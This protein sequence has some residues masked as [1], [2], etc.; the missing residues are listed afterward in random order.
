LGSLSND[1][2][3][4]DKK[5]AK[6]VRRVRKSIIPKG[7][8]MPKMR[9]SPG[10][11]A[12]PWIFPS[13]QFAS[14]FSANGVA[15]EATRDPLCPALQP[16]ELELQSRYIWKNLKK[17]LD[18][19]DSSLDHVVRMDQFFV[20]GGSPNGRVDSIND[21]LRVRNEFFPAAKGR[22]TST[23][24]TCS[25]LLCKPAVL[26]IDFVAVTK[27]SGWTKEVINSGRIDSPPGGYSHAVRVGPYVFCSGELASD[28]D[29]GVAPSTVANKNLW[30]GS[31]MERQTR[32]ILDRLAII[33][34]D[35]ESDLDLT[36]KAQ[37]YLTPEGMKEIHTLDK[38]W[39]EY[40]PK[41]PP[42]RTLIPVDGLGVKDCQIEINL[43]AVTK[44]G[45]INLETVNARGVPKWPLHEPHAMKAGNL[46]FLSSALATDNK[47][48]FPSDLKVNPNWP[49]YE[50]YEKPIIQQMEY[51]LGNAEKVVKAAGGSGYT[52]IVR[53]Q[54]FHSEYD[55]FILTWGVWMSKYD[56]DAPASTTI[57]EANCPLPVLGAT[58]MLDLW[59]Y[60]P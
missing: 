9:Y 43:V 50:K 29:H 60:I 25:N 22:P 56:H 2:D 40:F 57:E 10:I 45:G 19:G 44:N 49:W 18:A 17:V 47:G 11:N 27:K 59:A 20:H 52:N 8:P 4:E 7:L 3:E 1:T 46:L 42:A 31:D 39:K 53:R 55:E 12:G 58:M 51:I 21:Y 6:Q 16:S 41:N 35:A 33:L 15:P 34:E 13:G 32:F 38:V 48:R 28:W 14:D 24:I 54:C 23:G 30:F 5:L 37:V 26:E 36:A